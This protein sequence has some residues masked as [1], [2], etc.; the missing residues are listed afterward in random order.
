MMLETAVVDRVIRTGEDVHTIVV[1]RVVHIVV[2]ERVVHTVERVVHTVERVV[3][4][5][6]VERV[7]HTVERVVH[8]AVVERVIHTVEGTT[9]NLAHRASRKDRL[10]TYPKLVFVTFV[11]F[12]TTIIIKDCMF[13]STIVVVQQVMH[14]ER[15][16]WEM[17][18]RFLVFFS[19]ELFP[20]NNR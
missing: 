5:V 15:E 10:T 3:H 6:V 8:T 9:T 17:W 16:I 18:E 13:T 7:V 1:E 4:T 2:V 12:V 20:S 11:T 19:P 14:W